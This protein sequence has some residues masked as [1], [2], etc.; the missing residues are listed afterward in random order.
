MR[1]AINEPGMRAKVINTFESVWLGRLEPEGVLIYVAT[2]WHEHDLTNHLM[3][4]PLYSFIFMGV[5]NDMTHIEMKLI[6]CSTTHPCYTGEDII[7]IPLWKEK[8]SREELVDRRCK[9]GEASF[10]R[11]YRN[12][13]WNDTDLLFKHFDDCLD[14]D[15]SVEEW[16]EHAKK[17]QIA[18]RQVSFAVGVDLSGAKRP[19]NVV[20][21]AGTIEGENKI[22]PVDIRTGNWTS[23]QLA[24]VI[25]D[26]YMTW[27]PTIIYVENVALQ[28]M[29][30]EWI[31]LQMEQ[32]RFI[33]M[34]IEGF[35]TG[36]QKS[37]PLVGLPGMEVEFK[38]KMWQICWK[39]FD[40]HDK[41]SCLCEWCRWRK[42][43]KQY[44]FSGD[45]DIVMSSW[46]TREAMRKYCGIGSMM[47]TAAD[48]R[49][50]MQ[51]NTGI[52]SKSA[53]KLEQYIDNMFNA[54]A[55]VMSTAGFQGYSW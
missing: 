15:T 9:T 53:E 43:M 27:K 32:G 29:L 14:C 2:V 26:V 49:E 20:F 22:V 54:P 48:Y 28:E 40:S 5:S 44:P 37:D 21:V 4:N 36:K 6:N 31:R 47:M 45:T 19:G 35:M 25:K 16:V 12:I 8:W 24:D 50:V 41:E 39:S 11:G 17:K 38:N 34:P 30:L 13:P 3:K 55:G 10:A 1:N 18:G 33:P 7:K 51:S 46:F 23:P 42:T 52:S